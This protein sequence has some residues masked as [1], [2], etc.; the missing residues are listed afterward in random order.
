MEALLVI[1]VLSLPVALNIWA[2][3]RILGADLDSKAQRRS[4]LALVWLLPLVGALLVLGVHRRNELPS[5]QYRRER[6]PGDDYAHSGR[7]VEKA[8]DVL[9]GD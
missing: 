8:R 6:D 5:R 4:Q 1:A 9:D 3:R 7:S 2:T